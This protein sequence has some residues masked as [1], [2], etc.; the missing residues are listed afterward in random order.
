MTSVRPDPPADSESTV[1]PDRESDRDG[2]REA[3]GILGEPT[4]HFLV[5]GALLFGADLYLGSSETPS[6]NRSTIVVDSKTVD[7]IEQRWKRSN[8][9]TPDRGQLRK[10]VEKW[11]ERELLVREALASGLHRVDPI[12]RRRLAQAMQ[13]TL[14]DG[15][16]TDRLDTSALRAYYREH[17]ER[18]RRGAHLSFRHVYLRDCGDQS[19]EASCSEYARSVL[20]QLRS[21]A[22]AS[23]F[24]APF[25]HGRRFDGISPETVRQRFGAAFAR[26]IRD[27]P[28]GRWTGPIDSSFGKHLVR[29]DERKPGKLPPFSEIRGAVLRDFRRSQG[30]SARQR[31]VDEVDDHYRVEVTADIELG[32]VP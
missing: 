19:P 24:G 14:A 5:A 25:A 7:R 31:A 15:E 17:R 11:I 16:G 29:V 30:R 10:A 9:S 1:A 3:P 13:T 6:S 18:Y 23:Q 8:G 28:T 12:V 2:R 32:S 4:V 22:E 27:R 21:G 20:E 26:A